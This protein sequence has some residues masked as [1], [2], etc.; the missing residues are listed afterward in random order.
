MKWDHARDA[1][2]DAFDR[3]IQL[4]EERLK[5]NKTP[6][7]TGQ[8]KVG[9]RVVTEHRTIDV[10]VEREEV[11]IEHHA[12]SGRATAGEMTDEEIVIPVKEERVS[13]SK[14]AVVTGEVSVG[15]RKVQDTKHVTETV[16][17]EELDVDETG[18]AKV[19]GGQT[20]H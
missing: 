15:K 11:V 3:T 1:V 5:V 2:R 9:K 14:E 13:V 6:V 16:R 19:K 17:K 8:V 20:R 7:E 4:R 12:A 10:P 18:S